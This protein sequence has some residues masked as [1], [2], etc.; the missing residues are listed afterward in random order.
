M[1]NKVYQIFALDETGGLSIDPGID[2]DRLLD[3]LWDESLSYYRPP[4]P[5]DFLT[6]LRTKN[7]THESAIDY[8]A[9]KATLGFSPAPTN[10]LYMPPPLDIRSPDFQTFK[11]L[12][13]KVAK[14][15]VSQKYLIEYKR[16]MRKFYKFLHPN[17]MYAIILDRRIY[18]NA[19]VEVVRNV[20][21]QVVQL[22][23]IHARTIRRTKEGYCQVINGIIKKRF[24]LDELIHIKKYAPESSIYGLPHYLAGIINL[25]LNTE[26]KSLRYRWY[27]NNAHLGGILLTNNPVKDIDKKTGISKKEEEFKEEVRGSKGLGSGKM[28]VINMRGDDKIKKVEDQVAYIKVGGDI[29][30]DDFSA[31]IKMTKEDILTM[32]RIYP[33]VMGIPS[34]QKAPQNIDKLRRMTFEDVIHPEQEMCSIAINTFLDEESHIDFLAAA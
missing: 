4:I 30:E 32:H 31:S 5:F 2:S 34:G 17:D 28:M 14:E 8:I 27:K 19:F 29:S 20:F 13:E 12:D 11:D 26:A 25:Y 10:P 6:R 21:R 15:R 22:R 24:T 3:I 7:S 9:T 23:H 1:T 18:G 16:K 33:E